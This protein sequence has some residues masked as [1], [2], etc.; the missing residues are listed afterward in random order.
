MMD[1]GDAAK[2]GKTFS[3]L[4]HARENHLSYLLAL[5]VLNSLGVLG[6]ATSVVGQCLP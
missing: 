6:S 2:I 1:A 3:V 5:L 4:A